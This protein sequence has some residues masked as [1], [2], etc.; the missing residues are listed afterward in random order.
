MSYGWI[1]FWPVLPVLSFY[2]WMAFSNA[3]HTLALISE[4]HTHIQSYTWL[5]VCSYYKYTEPYRQDVTPSTRIA[6]VRS[7]PS[8]AGER[9]QVFSVGCVD[10]SVL[11]LLFM[12]VRHQTSDSRVSRDLRGWNSTVPDYRALFLFVSFLIN[13]RHNRSVSR[14]LSGTDCPNSQVRR[15]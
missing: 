8:A 2:Y 10:C 11:V 14:V 12:T 3:F 7:A 5:H 1:D 15:V 6:K 13:R 4:Y 9:L